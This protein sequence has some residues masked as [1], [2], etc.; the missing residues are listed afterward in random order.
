MIRAVLFDLDGTL[1]P[2]NMEEFTKGYFKLLAKKAAPFGYDAEKLVASI[3]KGTGAMVKNDGSC[4]NEEAFWKCFASIYGQDAL[5]D[6]AIFDEFYANEF[7]TAEQFCQFNPKAKETVQKVK[8]AGLRVVLATNPIFPEV[9]T[10]AR[11][12]W[13]GFELCDFE[14]HTTYEN[15]C[16]C[17]PNPE[18]YKD[19]LERIGCK[20][21]ECLMVGNDVDE[22]MVAATIGMKV[23]LLTDCLENKGNKDYSVYPHG[24]FEELQDYVSLECT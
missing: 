8:D 18:Y 20:P 21:E 6:K 10:Q 16:H 24:S 11:A 12:R 2:M 14:Y 17:K 7:L 13:A 3:W 1:L 9:A 22:D 5:K 15:S 23:F 4:S 19:I